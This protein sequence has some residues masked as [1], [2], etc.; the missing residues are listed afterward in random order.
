M[1]NKLFKKNAKNSFFVSEKKPN[2]ENAKNLESFQVWKAIKLHN[3][4]FRFEELWKVSVLD[5]FLKSIVFASFLNP[6]FFN[7]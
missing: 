7:I 3:L 2:I 5:F 1:I 6:Q 4:M